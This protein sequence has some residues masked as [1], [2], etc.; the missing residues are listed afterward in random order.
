MIL[1]KVI[2]IYLLFSPV[3]AIKWLA[4]HQI[5]P[6]WTE[7]SD[8][9]VNRTE[10]KAFGLVTY[11]TRLCRRI[12]KIMPIMVKAAQQTIEA[13]QKTFGDHRW[14]C[15]TIMF[16]PEFKADLS[17]GTREQAFVQ[18]L[19]SAAIVHTVAKSCVSGELSCPCGFVE[20]TTAPG[21]VANPDS[22][23]WKGCSDNVIY[24]RRVSREWADAI[25]RRTSPAAMRKRKSILEFDS[26]NLND[27]PTPQKL[28]FKARINQENNDI[29][30]QVTQNSQ[31]RRCKC[32]GVSSSCDVKTCW[33][34]LPPLQVIA[35]KLKE[36]YAKA[37][38][39]GQPYD[40]TGS[41]N[42]GRSTRIPFSDKNEPELVFLRSSP[43]YCDKDIEFGS[44]GTK[45]RECKH[46]ATDLANDESSNCKN[47]CCDRGFYTKQ[48]TLEYQCNCKYQH[49]C[50]VKCR[51]C[52]KTIEKHYCK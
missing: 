15:S 34:M 35:D 6:A 11:Q 41:K 10:R 47:L 28:G 5:Y 2:F 39:I 51:T 24:G 49:C 21:S 43:S 8:C 3:L 14:N 52:Q 9:P 36:R 13:C 46:N 7:A 32:H 40:P 19:S 16:A 17:K 38:Q 1:R 44:F 25:W 50:F 27:D 42:S 23:K 20:T 33:N 31:F 18:S 22:Y 4:M 48:F 45:D 12:P 26:E 29:G 37:Y 30:R